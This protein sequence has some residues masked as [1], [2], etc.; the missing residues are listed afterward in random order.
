MAELDRASG[1]LDATEVE[2]AGAEY[3]VPKKRVAY[4][5]ADPYVVDARLRLALVSGV[6]RVPTSNPAISDELI[7]QKAILTQIK[8]N[9]SANETLVAQNEQ[10]IMLLESIAE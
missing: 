9:T 8:F 1:D 2:V 4:H 6:Y 5:L 3:T 10:I 7:L